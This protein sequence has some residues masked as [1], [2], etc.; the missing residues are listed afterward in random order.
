MSTA[1][2]PAEQLEPA[3]YVLVIADDVFLRK[4][5]RRQLEEMGLAVQESLSVSR[6]LLRVRAAWPSLVLLDPWVDHG[7]GLG[8]MEGVRGQRRD[9]PVLLV[10]AEPRA[11][12][13]RRAVEMGALGHVPLEQIGSISDWV[14]AALCEPDLSD[15]DAS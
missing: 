15:R 4:L 6:G 7:A 2:L 11:A 10:G 3:G 1:L 9:V 13:L 8:F 5:V 12:S 14:D